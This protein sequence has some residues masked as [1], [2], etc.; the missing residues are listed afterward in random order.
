MTKVGRRAIVLGL[1][2]RP[3]ND[4]PI[5]GVERQEQRLLSIHQA[6]IGVDD[7]KSTASRRIQRLRTTIVEVTDD[8]RGVL[9][10]VLQRW[11]ERSA[12]DRAALI[13]LADILRQHADQAEAQLSLWK[14]IRALRATLDALEAQYE[15]DLPKE[16]R[17]AVLD[18]GLRQALMRATSTS[19]VAAIRGDVQAAAEFL[20]DRR[21]ALRNELAALTQASVIG[22]DPL[23]NPLEQEVQIR[24]VASKQY[25]LGELEAASIS[26]AK[27]SADHLAHLGRPLKNAPSGRV[28]NAK[29]S[30]QRAVRLRQAGDARW[31]PRTSR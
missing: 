29:E 20:S 3:P 25:A 5:L 18:P 23:P 24:I 30:Q 8:Q 28:L 22:S 17:R 16:W 10:K 21:T 6:L 15:S 2:S 31:P 4:S 1:T 26:V 27:S 19:S 14:E 11:P 13:E 7:D 12:A 9:A